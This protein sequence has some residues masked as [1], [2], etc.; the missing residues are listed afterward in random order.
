MLLMIFVIV[1]LKTLNVTP[2][3]TIYLTHHAFPFLVSRLYKDSFNC[4]LEANYVAQQMRRFGIKL[5]FVMM[6]NEYT[7]VSIEVCA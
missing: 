7:T 4:R 5:V 2:H 6:E 1:F 3:C